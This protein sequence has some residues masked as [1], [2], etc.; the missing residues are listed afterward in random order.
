MRG[1]WGR[2][3]TTPI[4]N[5]TNTRPCVDT[6]TQCEHVWALLLLSLSSSLLW[7]KNRC[8]R[9]HGMANN[10]RLYEPP[11]F[12]LRDTLCSTEANG[13]NVGE[14]APHDSHRG[15]SWATHP[16]CGCHPPGRRTPRWHR[17]L[18]CVWARR[19]LRW[20]RSLGPALQMS[21]ESGTGQ[22]IARGLEI[23]LRTSPQN[24]RTDA[25]PPR[26]LLPMSPLPTR[27]VQE[28]VQF[29]RSR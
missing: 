6:I 1:G 22:D 16:G 13:M 27:L 8:V 19:S 26:H 11:C 5:P 17:P 25:P 9:A 14:S 7:A 29:V 20:G 3:V 15:S 24:C 2:H 12:T 4:P 18:A 10:G 23:P 21:G 28:T